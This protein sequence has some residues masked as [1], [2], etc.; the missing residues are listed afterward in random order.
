MPRRRTSYARIS[1]KEIRDWVLEYTLE[2]PQEELNY[3][4]L[5]RYFRVKDRTVQQLLDTVLRE[6]TESG[7]LRCIAH[8]RYTLAQTPKD[9]IGIYTEPAQEKERQSS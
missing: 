3:R 7:Y 5:A 8:G 4:L 2:Y 6:L 9:T 1:K